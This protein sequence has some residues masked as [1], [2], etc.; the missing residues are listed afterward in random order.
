[1]QEEKVNN[2]DSEAIIGLEIHVQMKTRSKMFSSSPNGF[3]REPNT[4]I[5]PFDMAFPGTM[6]TVNKTA[7]INAIRVANALHMQIDRLIRFDRKNYFYADLPKGYQ[8]TQHFHPIGREGYLDILD[9]NGNVKRVGIE[10]V[11]MEE[12][13]CKQLHFA[14][15]T[16]LDYNRAGVPLLEIV[17][18]PQI[19]NGTEAMRFVDAIRKVVVYALVSDGKMEEGSLRCDVNVSL[20]PVGSKKF[21]TKVELKNLNSIRNIGAALDYE[22]ARQSSILLSGGKIQQETRRYDEAL[23]KTVLMRV[24]TDAVE[25]KYFPEPNIPPIRI[26]ERFV[27]DVIETCPELFEAKKAR[28]TAAGVSPV[29]AEIILDDLAMAQ[30]FDEAL[31]D[32]QYAKTISNLLIVE[33]KGYL[34][35]NSTAIEKFALRPEILYRLAE[36]QED[37]FTHKQVVDML[38]YCIENL[39]SKPEDAIKALGITKQSSDDSLVLRF[40]TEVLDANPQSIV[41]YKAGKD[42]AMGY[43]VGQV[44]KAAKGK[45]NP[46]AVAKVMAEELRKR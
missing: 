7:V 37:G 41:D 28:Y 26:S 18:Y 1:M 25:Y 16:L 27:R 17:S 19:R 8:I 42:R 11:H 15:C 20:R 39:G 21:G 23:G 6:P 2:M 36:L 10:R 24:K 14:D 46:S 33:V 32:G 9:R 35:K 3:S 22:I 44:M 38:N 29:D 30:Y 12:D 4:Q 40:V 45:L 5:T 34:N 43:L 31:G 13:T